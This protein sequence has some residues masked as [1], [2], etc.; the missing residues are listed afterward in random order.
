MKTSPSEKKKTKAQLKRERQEA[1][2][3]CRALIDKKGEPGECKNW[4]TDEN[5]YCGV[6]FASEMNRMTAEAVRLLARQDLE[7][8]IEKYIAWTEEHPHVWDKMP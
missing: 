2:G 4:A 6:H 3:K 5:G 1:L 7:E 8:R